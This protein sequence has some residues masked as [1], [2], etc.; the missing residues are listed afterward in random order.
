M[1]TTTNQSKTGPKK[2]AFGMPT[3]DEIA[4]GGIPGLSARPKVPQDL[5]D[6]LNT[7]ELE[8]VEDIELPTEPMTINMGPS[9]PATHGT[10]RIILTIDGETVKDSDVQV[11]YLHRCFEKEAEAATYTQV[12]PYTDRL[13]YVSPLLNNVGFALAVEKLIGIVDQLPERAK[14]IRVIIN[15]MMRIQ[16]HLLNI[17]TCALDLGAFTAFLY[18]FYQREL[19]YDLCEQMSGQ[20]FHSS[21]TRVGGLLYDIDDAWI[22]KMREFLKGF[23][24]MYNDVT[25]LLNRNKIFIDRL[26]GVGVL[27]KEEAIKD[28]VDL[29]ALGGRTER[30]R[31]VE[32]AVWKR[33]ETYSTGLGYGFAVPHCKTDA[34]G[35]PALAVLKRG[36]AVPVDDA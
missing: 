20:R 21:Y 12:F 5:M 14:Y 13:N 15:E 31:D 32:D 29:L 27:T 11:G 26:K 10:V 34:I 1:S 17:G 7:E 8:E 4:A 28:A 30:P 16:D 22:A 18:A 19:I 6:K 25:G 9:H 35:A 2:L 24:K 23:M 3:P 33:E 36:L